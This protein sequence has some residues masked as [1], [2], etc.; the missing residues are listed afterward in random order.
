MRYY[1]PGYTGYYRRRRAWN[2]EGQF[3]SGPSEAAVIRIHRTRH[4]HDDRDL[5]VFHAG[6]GGF[7][8]QKRCHR[9]R[10]LR[11]AH[12]GIQQFS[13]RCSRWG[14]LCSDVRHSEDGAHDR[15][16]DF[17]RTVLFGHLPARNCPRHLHSRTQP[18]RTRRVGACRRIRVFGRSTSTVRGWKVRYGK[19]RR[20]R[21]HRS[22]RRDLSR[23]CGAEAKREK[24]GM[25]II[26]FTMR[27]LKCLV[28][29]RYVISHLY[30]WQGS[31]RKR[32]YFLPV[33][34]KPPSPRS[35]ASSSST[36][37]IVTTGTS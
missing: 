22:C 27:I 28:P 29:I 30:Q 21:F 16:R 24:T 11:K 26:R 1:L 3:G 17:G 25:R 4:R 33:E 36:T 6:R 5:L 19:R 34:P 9:C 23:A 7:V 2:Q 8:I 10:Y 14:V 32:P 20:H 18:Y 13:R 31:A 35:V 15:I 12:P 37:S